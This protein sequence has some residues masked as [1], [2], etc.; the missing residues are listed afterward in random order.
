MR[1]Q[2]QLFIALFATTTL[3][4]PAAVAAHFHNAPSR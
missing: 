2:R 1:Y 3:L 4:V